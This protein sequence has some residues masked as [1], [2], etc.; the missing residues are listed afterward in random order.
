M[1][2]KEIR[3]LGQGGFGKVFEVEADSGERLA[4][5]RFSPAPHNLPH[6]PD[7]RQQVIERLRKRFRREVATQKQLSGPEIMPV[8]DSELESESPWFVMPLAEKTYAEQIQE[9][10]QS[11]SITIEAVADI[12][13]GLQYMHELGFVHRDLNPK[14]IL[15]H[16]GHWKLTDFGA[17]LPPSGQTMTLTEYTTILTELYCSPEQQKE[18]HKVQPPSD[19]YSFGCV[20]HDLVSGNTR[21]PYAKH[22]ADG[23]I[24]MIIEK[25]TDAIPRK[26]PPIEVLRDL[27]LEA[28]VEAGG[29][30]A[31]EDEQAEEWLDK[32]ETIESWEDDTFE[33]FLRF[34][35]HLDQDARTDIHSGWVGSLSTPFL[36]RIPASAFAII[37]AR[38]DGLSEAIIERY[39]EWVR[40]TAFSFGFADNI[41]SRLRAI[42]ENGTS[43]DKAMAFAALVQL[44]ASHNRWY[45]MRTA[46][47][48]CGTDISE[49]LAKRLSIE[50]R[51][52]GIEDQF[53]TCV[54]V[55][56][57]EKE[58]LSSEFH[59]L[60]G[61]D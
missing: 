58:A 40:D 4:L 48:L 1:N 13:N 31:V 51:T 45:V 14:N 34:F 21:T 46:L 10:R 17:V 2:Y 23:K 59:G 37:A 49:E 43:A 22:S 11:G 8:L 60:V 52:E 19:I 44:G 47:R 30:F 54:G 56:R 41:C 3:Q 24:G 29:H 39:C 7:E 55:I 16:N 42:F 12:M 25:C 28:L 61:G 38:Q 15:L 20:L 26:R 6:R 27:V 35:M 32:I 9:D 18:F 33:S 53:R 57:W 36:T 50:I 5:K